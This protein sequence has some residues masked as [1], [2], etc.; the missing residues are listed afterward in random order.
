MLSYAEN[1]IYLLY[2]SENN[3]NG[4]VESKCPLRL[5]VIYMQKFQLIL[6]YGVPLIAFRYLSLLI[7]GRAVMC[8][9]SYS[10][11]FYLLSRSEFYMT[12]TR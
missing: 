1:L 12:R 11:Q 7:E 4:E 10:T 5:A 2:R 6:N 3:V 8:V 9:K